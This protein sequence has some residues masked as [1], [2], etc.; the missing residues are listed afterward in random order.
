MSSVETSKKENAEEKALLPLKV[1]IEDPNTGDTVTI[2][3]NFFVGLY[4]RRDEN[5]PEGAVGVG[6]IL[7]GAANVL[8]QIAIVKAMQEKVVPIILDQIDSHLE[9]G[10][11]EA[12]DDYTNRLGVLLSTLL[13]G[14]LFSDD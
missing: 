7:K 10:E 13:L 4:T 9:K 14:S 6:Q 8:E 1:T 11:K 2:Q 12:A 5:A 3:P